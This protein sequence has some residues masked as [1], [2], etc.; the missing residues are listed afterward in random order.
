M[1]EFELY[2]GRHDGAE[3]DDAVD[4][5]QAGLKTVNGIDLHGSGNIYV[6]SEGAQQAADEAAASAAA[7][8]ESAATVD[9]AEFTRKILAAFPNDT[10][11]GSGA[12]FTDGADGIPIKSMTAQIDPDQN[13]YGM[14]S[15]YPAGATNNLIPDGTDTSN[16]YV[17]SSFLEESGAVTSINLGFY[18]SE[19]FPV[20]GGK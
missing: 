20:T 7:A 14:D 9:S 2:Q 15:P 6:G 13:L 16:G 4:T 5:V 3:I 1:D 12:Y 17:A 18:V 8:A 10:V 19:Y 11:S